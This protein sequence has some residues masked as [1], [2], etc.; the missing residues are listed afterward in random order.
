MLKEIQY[1]WQTKE[2]ILFS[3]RI[4]S[5]EFT[6]RRSFEENNH[7]SN[8]FGGKYVQLSK[9]YITIIREKCNK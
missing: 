2:T 9:R 4:D 8:G 1:I 7:G 6:A 5:F 3:F